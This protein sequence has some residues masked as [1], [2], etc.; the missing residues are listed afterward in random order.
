MV[1]SI[2]YRVKSNNGIIF[3]RWATKVLKDHLLKGYSINQKRLDYLE[4]LFI[5]N[6]FYYFFYSINYK[7]Y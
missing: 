1:I 5:I 4:K 6:F 3:R 7:E 2:G